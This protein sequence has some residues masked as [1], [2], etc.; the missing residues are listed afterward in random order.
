MNQ[1]TLQHGCTTGRHLWLCLAVA[2]GLVLGTVKTLFLG[3]VSQDS[4]ER[5]LAFIPRILRVYGEHLQHTSGGNAMPYTCSRL[6]LVALV[7]TL[8]IQ[9]GY[10]PDGA[11]A[12]PAKPYQYTVPEATNDGWETAHVSSENIDAELLKTLFDRV[13]NETYKNIHSVLL[14]KN[15]KLVVEEYFQTWHGDAESRVLFGRS[16]GSRRISNTR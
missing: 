7:V 6:P 11:P 14:I 3:A 15:D 2:L 5:P 4:G 9:A 12:N 13:L 1:H 8:L 10:V 16:I